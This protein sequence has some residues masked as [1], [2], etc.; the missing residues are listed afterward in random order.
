LFSASSAPACTAELSHE[1]HRQ[2]A[3]GWLWALASLAV[4]EI[5]T[6]FLLRATAAS[7]VAIWSGSNTYSYGFVVLPIFG[8]LVWRRWHEVK[9]LQPSTSFVGIVLTLGFAATWVLG[10]VADVQ[11][12][13]QFAFIGLLEALILAFLGTEIVRLLIFPLAFLFFA[14]PAGESLVVPLQRITA[15]FTVSAVRLC[16]IPAVQ[17]GFVF[18]TPSGDWKIAEACSGI[19]YL[20]SSFVVGVLVAGVAFR[21]WRRRITFVLISILVPIAA[22]AVRA[23]LIVFLANYTSV[24]IASGVDHLIYGW[25]FFSLVTATLIGLALRWREPEQEP[26]KLPDRPVAQRLENNNA[27]VLWFTV[28]A[29]AI[30]VCTS[31]ISDALWSRNPVVAAETNAWAAPSDWLAS[32]APDSGWTPNFKTIDSKTFA[33]ASHQVSVYV[34]FDTRKRR[35]VELVNSANAAGTTGGWDLLTSDYRE[36][37][38]AGQQVTVAEYLM[39][40][41]DGRRLVWTWYRSGKEMTAKPYQ[42]KWMQA[43]SRLSGHPGNVFVYAIST[44]VN[45]GLGDAIDILTEFARGMNLANTSNAQP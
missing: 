9:V 10:N 5:L 20:T 44:S 13:Q 15:I 8:L 11:V 29:I 25:I 12:V 43:M 14:V 2:A 39:G 34:G 36:A 22:N 42:I 1:S 31:T 41:V 45:N 35:G 26:A 32:F 7:M 18:S 40:S 33:K 38:V 30:V 4:A 28:A 17:D 3:N 27:R 23:F 21:S 16:G 19:R 6:I 37:Q 24:R